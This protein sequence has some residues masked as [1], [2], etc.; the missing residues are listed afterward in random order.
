MT[1]E[2]NSQIS[3]ITTTNGY[4]Y[5]V[6]DNTISVTLPESKGTS[7]KLLDG[8]RIGGYGVVWG[9]PEQKDLE[10]D[11]FTPETDFWLEWFPVEN[12]ILTFDHTMSPL[13][14]GV[15]MDS[16][17]DWVIGHVKSI[18]TDDYGL[19]VE[20]ILD[21]HKDWL[22][23][24]KDL[25]EQGVLHY[26][27]EAVS[28]LTERKSDGWLKS[29]ALVG[30]GVTH[31]PAEPLTRPV[32][33]LKRVHEL[34]DV[35]SVYKSLNATRALEALQSEAVQATGEQDGTKSVN[36]SERD[37]HMSKALEFDSSLMLSAL[38]GSHWEQIKNVIK[39]EGGEMPSV[40]EVENGSLTD[41]LT[42]IAE[43][44]AGML[45]ISADEALSDLSAY[46]ASKMATEPEAIEEAMP[47]MMNATLNIDMA[48]FA[49]EVAKNM[50]PTG[51]AVYTQ[52]GSYRT[53][54][55]NQKKSD[56]DRV[57]FRKFIKALARPTD[58]GANQIL[59]EYHEHAM[60]MWKAQGLRP[61]TA[62]G[63][64]TT[65]DRDTEIIERLA[66]ETVVA[67][68]VQN[69]PMRGDRLEVPTVETGVTVN[70]T[71]ENTPVTESQMSF[72]MKTAYAKK[73]SVLVPVSSEL[74]EDSDPDVERVIMDEIA[75][76][77]GEKLD[78]QILRGSGTDSELLGIDNIP[79]VTS[80]GAGGGTLSYDDLAQ[81]QE[82]LEEAN[83]RI[84]SSVR[85]LLD[86]KGKR[87]VREIEDS[88]GRLIFT[89]GGEGTQMA[90]VVPSY[91][92]D[93]QWDMSTLLVPAGTSARKIY[94]AKWSDVVLGRRKMIEFKSSDQAGNAFANDQV[95][96][97]AIMR[98]AL[99]VRHPESIQIIT[100][101]T[102][103]ETAS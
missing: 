53:K 45:G 94:L 36:Q 4:V 38:W 92:L 23:S 10:G 40:E 66:A 70:T 59:H 35:I 103:P 30:F 64:L 82:R 31:H 81:A 48:A 14:P 25:I 29:W 97:R 77:M 1:R 69:R 12:R 24:V 19:W 52:P 99:L 61:D 86:P 60:K 22:Q 43:Q 39:Q 56:N 96:I 20:C 51:A 67:N 57:S 7:I 102:G 55:V 41:L 95:L 72:G 21:E 101:I 88:T 54:G 91:L 85:W 73:L 68:L 50:K 65:P 83:V 26:S 49:Q 32:N 47:E 33:L 17:K 3:S 9:S 84:D 34:N 28:H 74:L 79:G 63:F 87:I 15:P 27:S 11:Y 62:G 13:P 46:V 78:A 6:K 42:P 5:T 89:A 8:N 37:N 18:K 71:A 16:K 2:F 93:Y 75:V 58:P 90:G 44:I 98:V 80:T 76:A 100:G